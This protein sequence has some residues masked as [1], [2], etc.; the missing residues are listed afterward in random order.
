METKTIYEGLEVKDNG[1]KVCITQKYSST[2]FS[3]KLWWKHFKLRRSCWEEVPNWFLLRSFKPILNIVFDKF[4]QSFAKKCLNWAQ[5]SL[6]LVG[7]SR[8]VVPNTIEVKINSNIRFPHHRNLPPID[9][10]EIAKLLV[11]HTKQIRM[12]VYHNTLVDLARE[13]QIINLNFSFLVQ[14]LGFLF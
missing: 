11:L 14:H 13:C 4:F 6:C 2:H 9:E 1:A 5:V 3:L 12:C 10:M 7:P 8:G